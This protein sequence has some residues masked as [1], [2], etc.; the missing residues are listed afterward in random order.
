MQLQS[1]CKR[2]ASMKPRI[3]PVLLSPVAQRCINDPEGGVSCWYSDIAPTT[4]NVTGTPTVT[5][6]PPG[7]EIPFVSGTRP[8]TGAVPTGTLDPTA[9]PLASET[10]LATPPVS[11]T[12]MWTDDFRS[13]PGEWW[14]DSRGTSHTVREVIDGRPR[15]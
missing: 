11:R 12:P 1:V 6:T 8:A 9:T 4:R 3:A 2:L 13:A 10:P 7:S 5:Y 15:S 14:Y